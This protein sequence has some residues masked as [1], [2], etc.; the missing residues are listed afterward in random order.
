MVQDF[1]PLLAVMVIMN[2]KMIHSAGAYFGNSK[3]TGRLTHLFFF[4]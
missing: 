4:D 1:M 3:E 2:A